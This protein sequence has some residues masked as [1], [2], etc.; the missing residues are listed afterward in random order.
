MRYLVMFVWLFLI[1]FA[2]VK[3][4]TFL[5]GRVLQT[6]GGRILTVD[7]MPDGQDEVNLNPVVLQILETWRFENL[8]GRIL[9]S[10]FKKIPRR[11]LKTLFDAA[12]GRLGGFRGMDSSE[13][14]KRQRMTTEGKILVWNYSVDASFEKASAR[15][16]V[17]FV[18]AKDDWWIQ[19]FEISSLALEGFSEEAA[20]AYEGGHLH[21]ILFEMP[22]AGFSPETATALKV[23]QSRSEIEVTLTAA[24]ELYRTDNGVYPSTRQGLRAL[25]EPPGFGPFPK[26]WQ[27]PYIKQEDLDDPWQRRYEYRSPARQSSEAFDLYS[28]GPNGKGDGNDADDIKNW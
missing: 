16:E 24:L 3:L 15:I 18:R 28:K 1:G 22:A 13:W 14:H 4:R 8:E 21:S 2:F 7:E 9:P 5:Y 11:D 10:L 23:K 27:G 19:K 6:E 12:G 25:L 20:R 26:N 17:E